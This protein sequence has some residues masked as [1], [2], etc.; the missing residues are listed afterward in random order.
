MINTNEYT[1]QQDTWSEARA[2]RAWALH[3]A[4]VL[5]LDIERLLAYRRAVEAG[6]YTDD[7]PAIM[8]AGN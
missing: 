5:G 8:P 1:A 2:L 3:G 4:Q 7:L 6:F